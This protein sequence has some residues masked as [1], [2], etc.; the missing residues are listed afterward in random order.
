MT[1]STAETIL[2]KKQGISERE[3]KQN[4]NFGN[5]DLIDFSRKS[6][7][8]LLVQL[9]GQVMCLRASMQCFDYQ[10]KGQFK[11]PKEYNE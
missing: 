8:E 5:Y 10:F 2:V 4:K 6:I 1:L 3:Y 9:H 11:F 7:N